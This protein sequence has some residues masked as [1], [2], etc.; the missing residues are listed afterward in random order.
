MSGDAESALLLG[1]RYQTGNRDMQPELVQAVRWF[2]KAAELGHPLGA[3]QLQLAYY[4]GR[5]VAR[6]PADVPKWG[7]FAAALARDDSEKN[8]TTAKT[9]ALGKVVV[10]AGWN[11]LGGG[12]T[13]R[14]VI[15][16]MLAAVRH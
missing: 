11:I 8:V 12:V 1:I 3:M 6:S 10:L 15:D 16:R 2:R 4:L 5:G 9:D 13:P 7:N 14:I